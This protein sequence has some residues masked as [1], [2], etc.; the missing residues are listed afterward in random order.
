[1]KV[2]ELYGVD[3]AYWVATVE[4][5]S[6]IIR[7]AGC[8]TREE[9]LGSMPVYNKLDL[10]GY[11]YAPHN[12]W[13]QGGALIEKYTI[14]LYP[15]LDGLGW[16]AHAHNGRG[17]R[18]EGVSPLVAATRSVIATVYGKELPATSVQSMSIHPGEDQKL[19][20]SASL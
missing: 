7:D 14:A 5:L 13:L 4:N 15:Y 19:I 18:M 6:P 8:L 12:N 1:M 10:V 16:Y 11:T 9:T 2:A 20:V 17:T 3:L